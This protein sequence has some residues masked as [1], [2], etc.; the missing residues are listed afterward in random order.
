MTTND[1]DKLLTQVETAIYENENPRAA[2][3]YLY[4]LLVLVE[5]AAFCV[6]R[7]A[8][9]EAKRIALAN[10]ISEAHERGGQIVGFVQELVREEDR[11]K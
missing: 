8:S 7:Y 2:L 5:T 10:I 3:I 6:Q 4:K 1:F 11:G 9:S